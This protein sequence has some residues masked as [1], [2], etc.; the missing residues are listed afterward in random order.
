MQ[1]ICL[2]SDWLHPTKNSYITDKSFG[3]MIC[4]RWG[5]SR[6]SSVHLT[7]IDCLICWA[8][9]GFN[10]LTCLGSHVIGS[11]I[12]GCVMNVMMVAD[13]SISLLLLLLLSYHHALIWQVRGGC[14]WDVLGHF[15]C[16]L[17]SFPRHPLIR[18]PNWITSITLILRYEILEYAYVISTAT[19]LIWCIISSLSAED[20]VNHKMVPVKLSVLLLCYTACVWKVTAELSVRLIILISLEWRPGHQLLLLLLLLNHILQMLLLLGRCG[21]RCTYLLCLLSELNRASRP[22]YV[23]SPVHPLDT[24][25]QQ[26]LQCLVFFV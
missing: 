2:P 11:I 18:V 22:R 3:I 6:S 8:V 10:C 4:G 19:P 20:G 16:M 9:I 5:I 1:N 17:A 15:Q 25:R 7:I 14:R 24:L 26:V 23:A 13:Y 12:C 21:S